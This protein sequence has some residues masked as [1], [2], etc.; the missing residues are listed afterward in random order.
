MITKLDIEQENLIPDEFMPHTSVLKIYVRGTTD[1]I[2]ELHSKFI[3]C[4]TTK[5]NQPNAE[6]GHQT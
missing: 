4:I 1:H 3:D 5:E 6:T 2:T